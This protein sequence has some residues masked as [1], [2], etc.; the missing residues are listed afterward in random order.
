MKTEV[1]SREPGLLI[2]RAILKPG[3]ATP[4]H[5][6]ACRRFTVVVSGD[7]LSIEYRDGERVDLSVQPG[8]ADW[9]APQWRIHR[10][11]N[12]GR[13]VFQEV[14]TFYLD[15]ADQDPQPQAEKP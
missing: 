10:A 8:L 4:W 12:T 5:R 6:D 13:E 14:V 3:E 9:E 2:H 1:I 7:A 11:V 15:Q